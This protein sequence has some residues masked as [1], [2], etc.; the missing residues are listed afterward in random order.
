MESDRQ[1]AQGT[2]LIDE[3]LDAL[4]A[5]QSLEAGARN[6]NLDG[7]TV[8]TTILGSMTENSLGALAKVL[9]SQLYALRVGRESDI[10]EIR[11]VPSQRMRSNEFSADGRHISM[12]SG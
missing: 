2:A 5:L 10:S 6:S 1:Q 7:S 4:R 9:R 3:I 11:R 12:R 8:I